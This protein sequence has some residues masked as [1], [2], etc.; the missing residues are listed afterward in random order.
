MN[1]LRT[2]KYITIS[3]ALYFGWLL[4]FP[5]YGPVLHAAAPLYEF[6]GLSLSFIFSLSHTLAF[7]AGGLLLKNVKLWKRL[8][9]L[10]LGVSLAVSTALLFSPPAIWPWAMVVLG[11]SAS[12][13]ILGWA[14]PYATFVPMGARLKL[15]ASVIIGANIIYVFFNVLSRMASPSLL[16]VLAGIPLWFALLALFFF[17]S[18]SQ[19][20]TTFQAPVIKNASFPAPMILILCLFIAGLYLCSGFMYNIM[21][22]F[23]TKASP[24]LIYYR[25]IPY[26]AVLVIMWYFGGRLQRYFSIYMG[27]SLLGLAFVSFALGYK[28]TAG[29]LMTTGLSEAAFAFLDLFVWV[30]LGD[31]AFIYGAPFQFFGFALAAMLFSIIAGELIGAQLL[32][33]GEHY[34]LV[35]ALFAA[36]AI[37]L[38]FSVIPW[39]SEHI[40]KDLQ[41]FLK[42]NAKEDTENK[43]GPAEESHSG[44]SIKLLL[45]HYKLTPRETEIAALLLKGLTN[46]EI[47]GQ[48]FISE[49]TLKTHLRNI[50]PKY[51][52]SQKRELLSL[53]LDKKKDTSS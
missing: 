18:G 46:R 29:L 52:V 40:Q 39:L 12:L 50:Y 5:F 36:T 38:T 2:T 24:L 30:A 9:F 4:S 44:R 32:Q 41:W 1:G 20:E 23:L 35:T 27:V 13:Y 43:K 49:N 3:L 6:R 14:Y 26:I 48:L 31:L 22:P 17:Q 37:F 8:K 11:A 51:G 34:R 28:S 10:S 19:L 33:I 7:L 15:M 25:Y 47:A 21:Q 16:L 53:A 45:P 42:T